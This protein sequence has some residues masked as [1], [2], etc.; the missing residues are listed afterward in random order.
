MI[1]HL[2]LRLKIVHISF[3]WFLHKNDNIIE[4]NN[5]L[6]LT[7]NNGET[8]PTAA[9]PAIVLNAQKI[10]V[11]VKRKWGFVKIFI[12]FFELL[13]LNILNKKK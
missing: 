6:R 10:E 1:S 13:N 2:I 11:N 8:S 4:T 3:N 12:K 7:I 9:L 5:H